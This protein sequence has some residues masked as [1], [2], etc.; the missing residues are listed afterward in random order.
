M[1]AS[2]EHPGRFLL[3]DLDDA[4]SSV[5]ALPAAVAGAVVTGETS[6][7]VRA[8]AVSVPRLAR[9][10]RANADTLATPQADAWGVDLETGGA[11]DGL[12][13]VDCPR[14]AEPLG[15]G[16]VRVAVRATGVN[17]R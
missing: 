16:Q 3:V 14:A 4:P 9:V 1:T 7:A 10:A 17:F 11:L 13:L 15:A 8:G 2:S 5:L 6:L 12:R